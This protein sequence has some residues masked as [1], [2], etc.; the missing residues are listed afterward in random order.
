MYLV[1][2]IY[3]R[4][5]ILKI[6]MHRILCT[7]PVDEI[8]QL[9]FNNCSN[10]HKKVTKKSLSRILPLH[11]FHGACFPIIAFPVVGLMIYRKLWLLWNYIHVAT[12]KCFSFFICIEPPW[13]SLEPSEIL[14]LEYSYLISI[15]SISNFKSSGNEN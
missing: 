5:I 13:N 11:I 6:F 12:L 8:F 10:Y 4:K 9:I 2:M 15:L 1:I 14:P 7:V 3:Y